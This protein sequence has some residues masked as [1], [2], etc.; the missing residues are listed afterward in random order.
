LHQGPFQSLEDYWLWLDQQIAISSGYLEDSPALEVQPLV[1][2]TDQS[3]V[4]FEIP[5][6]RL[7]FHDGTFLELR[8][9]VIEDVTSGIAIAEYHLHYQ[10]RDGTL[11]WRKDKHAGHEDEHGQLEHI[12]RLPS[13]DDPEPY[14]EVDLREAIEEIWAYQEGM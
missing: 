9:R 7:R 10:H 2:A 4:G 8:L 12:H 13:E 11:I 3:W 5:R 1:H 6:Q 14:D